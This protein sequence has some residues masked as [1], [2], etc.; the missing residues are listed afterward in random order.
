M[1]P[2]P[3]PFNFPPPRDGA[4]DL[5]LVAGEH[6]GDE[7]AA[8]MLSG[9]LA[10]RPGARVCAFGGAALEGA[11][12]QIL[13]DTTTFSVVGLF[14]VLKNYFFF[15]NLLRAAADWIEK[16]SP[17]TVCFVDYPGFNMRL[18]AALKKRGVSLKGGGT[19]KLLYYISPQIWAWNARRRF[20]MA[21]LLDALAAIFPFETQCYADTPLPVSFVGHPFMDAEYAPPVEYDPGGGILLL[22]GSRET[23]VSRIFP[24]MASAMRNLPGERAVAVYPTDG[25]KARL[26]NA[27]GRCG[28]VADRIRLLPKSAAPFGAKAVVASSGTMSLACALEGIPGAVVYKANAFTYAVGR[29][30]VNVKYLGIANI[31]LDAPAWREF[32]QFDASA[33][34]IADYAS[35]ELLVPSARG[36]FLSYAEKLKK[37]LHSPPNSSASE[38][39]RANAG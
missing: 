8:K 22:A 25:I 17:K 6:S 36:R 13:F 3:M 34:R 23:A 37:A 16:Y 18:A 14:E 9:F 24:V 19:V 2:P 4:C 39:L 29:A 20:K 7:H 11:G 28:D 10:A 32:I 30:L 27:L 38:W 1:G 15:R 33:R 35:A 5:L 21:E 31:I 12:A 26:E